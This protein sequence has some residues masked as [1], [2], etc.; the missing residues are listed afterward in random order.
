[1]R[2]EVNLCA[3]RTGYARG[4]QFMR[5]QN[6]IYAVKLVYTRSEQVMRGEARLYASEQVMRARNILYAIRTS[7]KFPL[8]FFLRIRVLSS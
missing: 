3:L 1:M 2:D 8:D 4:S 6:K 7:Y 5:G